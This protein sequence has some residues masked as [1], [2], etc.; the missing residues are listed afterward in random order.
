MAQ[1]LANFASGTGVFDAFLYGGAMIDSSPMAGNGDLSLNSVSSSYM[2]TTTTFT[3]FANI[4]SGISFSGWFFPSNNQVVGSTIFDISAATMAVSLFYGTSNTLTGLFN[5]VDV[6]STYVITPNTWHFFCY[7]ILCTS[8]NLALQTIYIDN[9]TVNVNSQ[10]TALYVAFSQSIG[11]NYI[12]YGTGNANGTVYQYFN[13]KLDDFRFYNRVLSPPEINVLYNY[14]YVTNT[15]SSGLVTVKPNYDK[16]QISVV[17]IDV[18]GTFSGL[19]ISRNPA[20]P[21]TQLLALSSANLSTTSGS[22]WAFYD[23]NVVPDTSYIYMIT[24]RVGTVTGTMV[25]LNAIYTTSV[26]GG[27]FNSLTSGSLPANNATLLSPALSGWTASIGGSNTYNLNAGTGGSGALALYTGTLPSTV[28]YYVSLT[29]QPSSSSSLSQYINIYTN[30]TG[31]ISFFAWGTDTTYTSAPYNTSTSFSVSLGGITLLNN[32]VFPS[33]GVA[34]PYTSFSLPF[35]VNTLGTYNLVFT[36]LNNGA[37]AST[38]CFGNVQVRSQTVAGIGYKTIDPS[39]LQLYYTF[40]SSF[41]AGQLYNY[42]NGVGVLDASL[43]MNAMITSSNPSAIIGTSYLQLDGLSYASIGNWT[44]P[45]YAIGQGFSITGWVYPT[46]SSAGLVKNA[47]ICSLS[48]GVAA[49]GNVSIYMNN[50]NNVLDVSF[51]GVAGDVDISLVAFPLVINRWSF[52]SITCQGI[53]G[54][55]GQYSYYINDVSL[56]NITASWPNT[57]ATYTSN[58]LGGLP[59]TTTITGATGPLGNFTG[60]IEDFRVYNRVISPQD[61]FALWSLGFTNSSYTNLIDTIGLNLYFPF[62]Q[63]STLV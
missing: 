11:T 8:T 9:P 27:N 50:I 32:Y 34:I 23:T 38:V 29:E 10:Y 15:I 30:T 28:T 62:E 5:G 19:D 35:T 21:G 12:G 45:A 7:T 63:G 52:I 57:A 17:Q 22:P 44:C 49:S 31:F 1:Q 58:Y 51:E 60:C 59:S 47:T 42:A 2:K 56:N 3:T 25:Q 61:I 46:L 13:G 14:N 55:K 37:S 39:M 53:A 33:T 54:S 6:S 36:V 4:G 24:P 48:N 20:F 43:A 40:D 41:G 16:P 18:S 26:T